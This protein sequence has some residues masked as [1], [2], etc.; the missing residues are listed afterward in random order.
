MSIGGSSTAT[1]TGLFTTM[2]I[3]TTDCNTSSQSSGRV[4]QKIV[5]TNN[6]YTVYT[7]PERQYKQ[8][9]W[10]SDFSG[11]KT[12]LT[13]NNVNTTLVKDNNVKFIDSFSSSNLSTL[14]NNYWKIEDG[15]PR[16]KNLYW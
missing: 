13:I 4:E 15:E 3:E 1:D 14:G 8:D 2:Q 6:S 5:R 9:G 7:Y 11:E 16:L 10:L 12:M